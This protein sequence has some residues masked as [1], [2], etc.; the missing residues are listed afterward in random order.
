MEAAKAF[1]GQ[2]VFVGDAV[3]ATKFYAEVV[4]TKFPDIQLDPREIHSLA[5]MLEFKGMDAAAL[6]AYE[7]LLRCQPLPPGYESAWMQAARLC[8]KVSPDRAADCLRY[9]QRF[10]EDSGLMRDKFE[11]RRLRTEILDAAKQRGMDTAAIEAEATGAPIPA[12]AVYEA[13]SVSGFGGPAQPERRRNVRAGNRMQQI[14]PI[15]IEPS[16]MIESPEVAEAAPAESTEAT[17]SSESTQST[18]PTNLPPPI[19]LPVPTP[20][21]EP[22]PPV[23]ATD[24]SPTVPH[25]S[26]QGLPG[27]GKKPLPL[28]FKDKALEIARARLEEKPAAPPP[29][30][31]PDLPKDGPPPLPKSLEERLNLRTR[32]PRID[33]T[34]LPPP[35]DKDPDD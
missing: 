5:R 30:P 23:P 35:S 18:K 29:P 32:P 27:W 17:T 28:K 6:D 15:R 31:P 10:E 20:Q 22:T 16:E 2:R 9:L 7:R 26:P 14:A 3:R 8:A 25:D 12:T 1:L 11:A 24:P 33:L 4:M 13:P 21:E 34:N 19:K